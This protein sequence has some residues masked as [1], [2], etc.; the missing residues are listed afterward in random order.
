MKLA[1]FQH[2]PAGFQPASRGEPYICRTVHW[3]QQVVFYQDRDHR[4]DDGEI[5]K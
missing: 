3:S 1:G 5:L 2:G 4:V